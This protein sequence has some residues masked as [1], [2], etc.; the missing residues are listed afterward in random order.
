VVGARPAGPGLAH[1]ADRD[2][3]ALVP[4]DM[5]DM[6]DCRCMHPP[7]DYRGFSRR[8][9]GMDTEPHPPRGTVTH[10]DVAIET[11]TECGT[12]WLTYRMEE[13]WISRSGR[14]WRVQLQAG[15]G[16]GLT[17]AHAK[18]Y[19]EAQP[20]CFIGGSYWGSVEGVDARGHRLDHVQIV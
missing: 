14:W 12:D 17:A 9:L 19:L 1:D 8:S 7:F 13:E 11:C 18:P 20:W 3:I 15:D 2:R 5:T 4:T 10:A 6:T 16:E